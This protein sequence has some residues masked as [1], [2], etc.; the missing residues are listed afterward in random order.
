MSKKRGRPVLKTY[1]KVSEKINSIQFINKTALAE[2]LEI[3]RPSLYNK[4]ETG[5]WTKKEILKLKK[6]GIL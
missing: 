6:L 5:K 3:T 2:Q 1:K 4:L